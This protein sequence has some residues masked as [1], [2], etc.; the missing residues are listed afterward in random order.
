MEDKVLNLKI[1][2][3]VPI[4]CILCVLIIFTSLSSLNHHYEY[5]DNFASET[6]IHSVL[7]DIYPNA[8][9]PYKNLD[10]FIRDYKNIDHIYE[11]SFTQQMPIYVYVVSTSNIVS[12]VTFLLIFNENSKIENIIFLNDDN[13][14]SKNSDLEYALLNEFLIGKDANNLELD[15]L[16]YIYNDRFNISKGLN[17]AAL[18][19]IYEVK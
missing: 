5:N 13:T 16:S 3:L 18:N 11:L 6:A 1:I 2:I 12:N 7:Y 17:S 14:I 4:S 9:T 8:Y 19:L 10:Y 15:D